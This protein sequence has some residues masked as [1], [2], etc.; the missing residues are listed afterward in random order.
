VTDKIHEF[1]VSA[2]ELE[3]LKNLSLSDESLAALPKFQEGA[4]GRMAA[5]L[6][7]AEAAQLRDQLTMQLA[8]AGFD[9]NYSPNEQGN[10]LEELIDR[11]FLR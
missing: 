5:R 11:F 2:K 4:R 8:A 10:M 1:V 6:S 7:R 3:Y 9:E